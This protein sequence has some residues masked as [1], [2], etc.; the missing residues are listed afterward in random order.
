MNTTG[1]RRNRFAFVVLVVGLLCAGVLLAVNAAYDHKAAQTQANDEQILHTSE[2]ADKIPQIK[3][4]LIE[5]MRRGNI[6]GLSIAVVHRGETVYLAGYG[7]SDVASGTRADSNTLYQLA[8]NSKAFTALGVLLLQEQG[9]IELSEPITVYLPWLTMRYNNDTAAPTVEHFLHHTSGVPSRT[10]A[11]IP[12]DDKPGAI[13]RAVRRLVETELVRKPGSAYEYATIN[14]DVLGL[15]IEQVT[16]QT[17]EQFITE[18][19]LSPMG[20]S[21]THALDDYDAREMA[22]GY[23]TG[24]GVPMAYRAP[25][26]DGNKPAGYLVSCAADMA[27]WLK[28]QLG[29][30]TESTLN[31]SPIKASHKPNMTVQPFG[32]GLYYAAGWITD[33]NQ[34]MVMHSG[35]NPNYSSNIL[36]L[37]GEEL[38]VAILCNT[39]ATIAQASAVKILHLLSKDGGVSP[40]GF[41]LHGAIDLIACLVLAGA[42]LCCG[43][44]VF[45]QVTL[46]REVR[47]NQRIFRM[48]TPV[49]MRIVALVAAAATLCAVVVL[50]PRLIFGGLDW[51]FLFV[52]YAPTLTMAIYCTFAAIGLACFHLCTKAVFSIAQSEASA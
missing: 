14:Y 45:K 12:I 27:K 48:N 22:T 38:G 32:D 8:S 6:P 52:W 44:I 26:Y 11:E 50:L 10:I 34:T 30:S 17:Y 23:K 20:L 21:D 31:Q 7:F 39:N 46:W 19:I 18:E 49:G 2:L 28:V 47:S 33:A 9:A 43:S 5:E 16:G 15:L 13:E 42:L 24:F 41:D 36:F 3:A 37:P 25:D 4:L 51:T 35:S 40:E 29:T 1:K